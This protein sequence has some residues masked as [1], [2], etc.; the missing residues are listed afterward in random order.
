MSVASRALWLAGSVS[1]FATLAA[2]REPTSASPASP[3]AKVSSP[4]HG[5]VVVSI[6][7][8]QLAAWIASERLPELPATGGFARLRREGAYVR[9]AR[10]AHAVTDTAPGHAALY[11]CAEPARSGVVS[12]ERLESSSD[13]SAKAVPFLR[14]NATHVVDMSGETSNFGSSIAAYALPTVADELRAARPKA[15]IVSISLKDRAAIPGG[16]RAP[17]ATLWFDPGLDRFVT[18]TAFATELPRWASDPGSTAHL[19]TLRATPWTLLDREFVARHA[20]TPDGQA[21]E[22]VWDGLS[23]SFPHALSDAKTPAKAFRASPLADAAILEL[24][25]SFVRAEGFASDTTLIA[26]S[27][28]S[29]DYVGHVYGID[30]WEAWD[31]LARLDRALG[32]FFDELDRA[33][34]ADGWAAVLAADHGAP[35]M[36]ET[37]SVPGA[38]PWCEGGDD[39]WTRPCG[40]SFRVDPSAL[41]SSLEAAARD[42]AGK[43]A[44]GRWVLGVLDPYV[45]LDPVSRAAVKDRAKLFAALI[46]TLKA[47]P[48]LLD[49]LDTASLPAPCS[50]GESLE[51]LVCRS[52]REGAG[53]IYFVTRPGSFVDVDIIPGHGTNHGS[54]WIFD[55]S[56][57]ILARDPGRVPAGAIVESVEPFET[58]TRTLA[59][60]LALPAPAACNDGRDLGAPAR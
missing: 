17:T 49:A 13:G 60:A 11:T 48:G 25:T 12:N 19:A 57:P 24:A 6:V 36:P 3:S 53:D 1:T 22:G 50:P 46:A 58:F 10:F 18:S 51:S 30:S 55:R 16:G 28:S 54:P 32:R 37:A 14:D 23:A 40:P 38:R 5:K 2:C 21:G 7:V 59:G 4:V 47:Q 15:S 26:V 43:P 52:F 41:M 44:S 33:V 8:D 27:L 31:N 45:I 9:E 35:P 39:R 42:A 34:G 29:N 56:I 20:R